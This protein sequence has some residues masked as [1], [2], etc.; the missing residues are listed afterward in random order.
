M[1]TVLQVCLV[2]QVRGHPV[3]TP[4]GALGPRLRMDASFC[5]QTRDLLLHDGGHLLPLQR[6]LP[7]VFSGHEQRVPDLGEGHAG[8]DHGEVR[9]VPGQ[10][11]FGIPVEGQRNRGPTVAVPVTLIHHRLGGGTQSPFGFVADQ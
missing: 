3:P 2:Q 4:A 1:V 10:L 5:Q 9:K 6:Q 7:A 11:A 8:V